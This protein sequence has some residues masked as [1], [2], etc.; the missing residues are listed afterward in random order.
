MTI[1][2]VKAHSRGK[3]DP[4][5]PVIEAKRHRFRS[6]WGLEITTANDDKPKQESVIERFLPWFRRRT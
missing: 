5:A 6:K 1:T 2:P 3:P 4:F